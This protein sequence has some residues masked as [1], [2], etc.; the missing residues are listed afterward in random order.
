VA[1]W[2]EGSAEAMMSATYSASGGGW[3]QAI[4]IPVT[5]LPSG[6]GMDSAGNA[7][8]LFNTCPYCETGGTG[9]NNGLVESTLPFGGSWTSQSDIAGY[10]SGAGDADEGVLA[11]NAAGD[12]VAAWGQGNGG[13]T[14]LAAEVL[15]SGPGTGTSM[16][17][18]ERPVVANDAAG[19]ATV[20]YADDALAA[21]VPLDSVTYNASTGTWGPVESVG[22]TPT[23]GGSTYAV[24]SDAAG[25]VTAVWKEQAQGSSAEPSIE[26]ATLPAG[27]TTWSTPETLSPATSSASGPAIAEDASGDRVVVWYATENAGTNNQRTALEGAFAPAGGGFGAAATVATPAEAGS[28]A[29]VAIDPHGNAVAVWEGTNSTVD[30]ASYYAQPPSSPPGGGSGGGSPPPTGSGSAPPSGGGTSPP[31]GGSAS[32]KLAKPPTATA[33]GAKVTLTCAAPVGQSCQVT[34]KLTVVE[35]SRGGTP[36]AVAAAARKRARTVVVGMKTVTIAGG[37]TATVTLTLNG[38]GRALLGRFGKLPAKLS[39][40]LRQAAHTATVATRT[41]TIKTKKAKPHSH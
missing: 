29:A 7:I 32:L 22:N 1:D 37:H 28:P 35:T 17:E 16:D 30:A 36:T 2:E 24:A 11:E 18:V 19:D 20:V 15:P 39:I 33:N 34:A 38:T 4:T 8:G 31:Q 6:L 23:F 21:Y 9:A 25:D 41:L 10:G 40:E 13:N 26:A 12:G 3:A 27:S 5:G 14:N